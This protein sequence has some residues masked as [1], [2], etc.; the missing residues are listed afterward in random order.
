MVNNILIFR[1]DRIGDLLYSCPTILTIKNNF[2]ESS[3]TLISSA[4]NELYAKKLNFFDNVFVCPKNGILKKIKFIF[5]I[6]KKKFDYI[7]VLDGKKR[8]LISILFNK[9]RNKFV[10]YPDKKIISLFKIFNISFIK[11]DGKKPI[12]DLFQ[13][14]INVSKINT[15][16]SNY[17]FLKNK[18]YED[19]YQLSISNYLHIHFDEKWFNNTYIKTL[20]EINPTEKDFVSFLKNVASKKN[21]ILITTGNLKVGLLEEMKNTFFIKKAPQIY[22]KEISGYP[23]RERE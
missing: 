15:K 12:N 13:E 20:S 23:A 19:S 3:L 8:S 1:T 4:K 6:L 16:I 7:F 2:P 18:K 5:F 22:F 21:H 11:D 14:M 17:D 10:V 9:C